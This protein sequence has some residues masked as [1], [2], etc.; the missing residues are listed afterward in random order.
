MIIAS[1]W[2]SLVLSRELFSVLG[3]QGIIMNK[4]LAL[5]LAEWA[6]SAIRQD[7]I[8]GQASP[9]TTAAII[10][11]ILKSWMILFNYYD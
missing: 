5:R 9:T 7:H 11:S 4:I 1:I 3:D 6:V 10:K 2:I 8:S